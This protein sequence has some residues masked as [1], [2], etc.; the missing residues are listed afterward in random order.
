MLAVAPVGIL[1]LASLAVVGLA[2]WTWRAQ[3][4]AAGG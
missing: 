2:G 3:A 4:R 1:P